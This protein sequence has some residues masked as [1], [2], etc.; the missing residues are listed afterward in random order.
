MPAGNSSLDFS[1][2]NYFVLPTTR[3]VGLDG[4]LF[5]DGWKD[6]PLDVTVYSFLF[7]RKPYTKDTLLAWHIPQ[8]WTCCLLTRYT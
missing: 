8:F 5:D 3:Y 2:G 6:M 4:A 1:S 7:F